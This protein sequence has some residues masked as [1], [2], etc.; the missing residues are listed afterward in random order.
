M[1]EFP[2]LDIFKKSTILVPFVKILKY[3]KNTFWYLKLI[4]LE[5]ALKKFNTPN[6]LQIICKQL[7]S[8]H[9]LSL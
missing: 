2:A 5:K 6:S 4:L 8:I 9:S 7:F 3:F 1:S